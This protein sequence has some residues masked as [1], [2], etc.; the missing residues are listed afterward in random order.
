MVGSWRKMSC[1]PCCFLTS[2]NLEAYYGDCYGL[3]D[4]SHAG[5]KCQKNQLM[6]LKK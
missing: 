6:A 4:L 1:Q 5:R 2:L 3:K